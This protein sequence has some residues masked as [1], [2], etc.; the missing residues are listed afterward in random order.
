MIDPGIGFGK[1]SA[2]NLEILG[3]LAELGLVEEE[4]PA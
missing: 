1:K 2:H 3:K 4:V